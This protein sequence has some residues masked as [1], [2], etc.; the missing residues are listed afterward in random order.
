V[1]RR[2]SRRSTSRRVGGDLSLYR[3]FQHVINMTPA[4]IDRWRKDP[5]H[6]DAS[7]PHIRAELPLLVEMKRA[8]MSRWTPKMWD[9]ALRAINFVKRHEAQMKV[10][11][12]RYGT[13]KMHI[14]YKRVAA[15]QNWGRKV[16][17]AELS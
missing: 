10:Q 2:I 16:R 12:K 4:E 7:L 14:T 15:L 5:R 8:P 13:G 11:G 17:G 6:L 3:D 1:A 9:K